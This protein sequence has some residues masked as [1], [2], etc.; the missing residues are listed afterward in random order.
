MSKAVRQILPRRQKVFAVVPAYNEAASLPAVLEELAALELKHPRR[1][2]SLKFDFVVVDDGS[3]DATAEVAARS[4]AAVVRLPYNMGIGMSV[5]TGFCHALRRGA[6]YV[7][8]VDGDG[9]H[10]PSEIEKLLPAI[11]HDEADVVVGS[12]FA[13]G[14]RESLGSTTLLRWLVGRALS[15]TVHFLTGELLTD[16]TSG[17]RVFNRRAAEFIARHYPDDYPEVEALVILA[18]HGFRIREEKVEMRS[19]AH[20]KSS[21]NWWRSLY[22]V[23]KVVFASFM[24]KMR[25]DHHG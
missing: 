18:I 9:Q 14:V 25:R 20:G 2:H 21:I 5:Q 17:F 4:G 1:Q 3:H 19:R 12:R 15:W 7:V 22:Y 10:I 23:P 24:D 13:H 11:V 16:T 6:D 8:Q